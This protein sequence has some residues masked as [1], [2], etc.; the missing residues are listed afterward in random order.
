MKSH[1]LTFFL[2]FCYWSWDL[3]KFRGDQSKKTPCSYGNLGNFQTKKVSLIPKFNTKVFEEWNQ[4][5]TKFVLRITFWKIKFILR[6]QNISSKME[7]WTWLF[8]GPFVLT[9]LLLNPIL[10]LF[11]PPMSFKELACDL[12]HFENPIFKTK[13]QRVVDF[14]ILTFKYITYFKWVEKYSILTHCTQWK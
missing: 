7:D 14:Y 4:R 11:F 12:T 9:N 8:I 5:Q 10:F 3:A 2:G 13:K 6:Y 1:T